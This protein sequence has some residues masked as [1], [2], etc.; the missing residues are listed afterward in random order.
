MDG[1][2]FAGAGMMGGLGRAA[3][4]LDAAFRQQTLNGAAGD[5]GKL[6]AQKRVKPF[7]G[8][9]LA[10]GQ[11]RWRIGGQRRL[12]VVGAKG[13]GRG[14]GSFRDGFARVRLVFPGD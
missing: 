5:G 1:N 14:V 8:Q 6:G 2:D 11:N 4:D 9:R 10:H 13:V 3:I 7:R 12:S